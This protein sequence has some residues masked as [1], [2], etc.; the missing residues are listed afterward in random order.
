MIG[1]P[2]YIGGMWDKELVEKM[3]SLNAERGGSKAK[4]IEKLL[5]TVREEAGIPSIGYYDLHEVAKK[6]GCKILPIEEAVERL[7]KAGFSASRT[8]FCPTAV[9]TDAPHG[10][11][12]EL[13][14]GKDD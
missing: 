13:L 14:S 6:R 8:H 9:R 5:H 3:V 2:L 7:R 4:E 10:K 12:L 1:G 11:A